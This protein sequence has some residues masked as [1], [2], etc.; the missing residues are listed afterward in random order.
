MA[1]R[2]LVC[3]A[4][5]RLTAHYRVVH[6]TDMSGPTLTTTL[7]VRMRPSEKRALARLAKHYE[8]TPSEVVRRLIGEEKARL[9]TVLSTVRKDDDHGSEEGK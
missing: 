6:D 1:R 9:D 8:R 2:A 5:E 3:Q 4:A 7:Q